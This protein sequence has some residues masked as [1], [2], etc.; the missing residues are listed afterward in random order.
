MTIRAALKALWHHNEAQDLV[1]YSLLIAFVTVA[2]AALFVIGA[3]G[4]LNGIW[5][6]ANNG[7][8]RGA[9]TAAAS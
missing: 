8:S 5:T 7:L 6:A 2:T 9:S 3:S 4:N 1:E